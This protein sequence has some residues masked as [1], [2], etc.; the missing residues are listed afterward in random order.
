MKQ[1]NK[2]KKKKASDFP[3]NLASTLVGISEHQHSDNAYPRYYAGL[4]FFHF[5]FHFHF[6]FLGFFFLKYI[7]L[8]LISRL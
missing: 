7:S 5:H 6:H 1:T 3:T 2:Q 8:F 4:F